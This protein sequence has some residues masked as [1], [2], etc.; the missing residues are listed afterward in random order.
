MKPTLFSM[1][2][3][4]VAFTAVPAQAQN[5]PPADDA[6]ATSDDDIIVFGRGETRQVQEIGS[7]DV[8][9]LAPGTS[10]LKAIEQLPG[11]N[12]QSADAF[13]NYEW[14]QRISI[15]SF[16]QNQIGFNFDGLP[17]GDG[18][19]GN[20]SGLHVSRA[21]ISE[22]VGSVRVSQGAGSIGTQATNNL[23]GTIETFSADPL[24]RF[25]IQFNSTYGSDDT[26]RG[27]V[28]ADFGSDNGPA[29]Y[30]SV[31]YGDTGKWKGEGV[32]QQRQVNVK[33]TAPVGSV[34]FDA[35]YSFS[36]RNE[37]DYQDLSL[38]QISRLGLDWDNFGT[39]QYALAIR[40]ADIA[41]NRGESGAAITNP[42]AGTIYP[43]PI[44]NVDDSYLD[45]SGI[46]RDH[47]AYVGLRGDIGS[48]GNFLIRTYYHNNKGQGLWGTPYV[49]S[50]NGVPISIR[51]TEYDIYRK[52]VF[53]SLNVPVANTELTIGGWYEQNDFHQARRFYALSSRTEQG[54][55]FLEFQRNPF[56]TQ[57]E[58][59]FSTE[60]LQYYVQD[61]V[62]LGALTINVG[63]KGF[64][65]SNQ[66]NP[67]IAD[68]RAGGSIRV[69]DWFQPH[70]GF[71]YELNDRAEIFGGFTQATRAFVSATT[72]G[73][74]S[75]TQAGFNV[76]RDT[77]KPETSDTYEF[78]LRY[79]S[80][81]FNGV[82]AGYY[83]DFS[84]RLLGLTTGAGIVGNPAVLQNVGS[85]RSYGFEAGGEVRFGDGFS[86]YF[87]Y[88]Y[89][90]ATYRDNVVNAVGAL[91]A[92]TRGKRVVDSPEHILRGELAYNSD[93]LFGRIGAG[94]LSERFFNFEND[95]SVG[96]RVVVDAT[97][98][99]RIND[100]IEVQINANNLFDEDYV[101]TIGSN[102]FGNRGDN[103]T[104]LAGAPQQFFGTLKVRY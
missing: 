32:Q 45:A 72:T 21:V 25:G 52:G 10:P 76:I 79:S 30:V 103:Q 58:F 53:G 50:P 90:D 29:G 26:W 37:Q 28:R 44:T 95:R 57:W 24:G 94:Y 89:N 54:R 100:R 91:V 86:A 69:E 75:T 19:Y 104:L 80:S 92:A 16:N 56:F 6:A 42:A 101:A 84:N 33:F 43:A 83:V 60:T 81:M 65:V 78:G 4:S 38:E 93:R 14:A 23:G 51:T 13:G 88:S 46:R 3:A 39:G 99:Y 85:V 82:L 59:D 48:E 1:L 41:A 7:G 87:A 22:N 97:I 2:A 70:V 98:G 102:G 5:A 49:P 11:V 36:R 8:T 40:V 12:F 77:L 9:I 34:N 20:N 61:K 27:Y 35:W 74:F 15:R 71:A 68:G 64:R 17:L 73:P 66:A 47:L 67:V 18:S 96:G 63:W 62:D 55:S 31:L